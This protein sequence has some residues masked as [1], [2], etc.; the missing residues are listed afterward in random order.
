M[1]PLA[2]AVVR[3][4]DS[5]ARLFDWPAP[6]WVQ[7]FMGAGSVESLGWDSFDGAGYGG[8]GVQSS[9]QA[10]LSGGRLVITG[11]PDGTTG[12]VGF[13]P[14]PEVVY[15]R[16]EIRYRASI[17]VSSPDWADYT[18]VC[19]L[20]PVNE[21]WPAGI[22][23]DWVEHYAG[24]TDDKVSVVAG[25]SFVSW[26]VN[27]N[28]RH[29][30]ADT[31]QWRHVAIEVSQWRVV[32]WADGMLVFDTR[33]KALIPTVAHRLGIQLDWHAD[34]AAT[35]TAV[36]EIDHVAQYPAPTVAPAA[37]PAPYPTSM[38]ASSAGWYL[39]SDAATIASSRITCVSNTA[40]SGWGTHAIGEMSE[41][42]IVTWHILTRTATTHWLAIN[43][44][45]ES[46]NTQNELSFAFS[47]TQVTCAVKINN[48][49][50]SSTT[51]ARGTQLY[52]R[53]RHV[54]ATDSFSW[55][56]SADGVTW[57][58]LWTRTQAQV[59]FAV[60]VANV[61]VGAGG[62]TGGQTFVVDSITQT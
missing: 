21:S 11:L 17:D 2:R 35:G 16:W 33:I 45:N 58:S 6:T 8:N 48:V 15:G 51:A 53:I 12:A 46:T 3:A 18:A 20:W 62:D 7:D 1:I 47:T 31:T 14:S 39:A 34:T 40:W 41:G 28:S 29:Y 43:S 56:R 55:D 32:V 9:A 37:L 22:E 61:E 52:W 23:I 13:W 44:G 26:G 54:V 24:S 59:G 30:A 5:H 10:V 38:L 42:R 19:L 60:M 49:T 50:Q 27:G 57:T 25:A 4:D 36:M